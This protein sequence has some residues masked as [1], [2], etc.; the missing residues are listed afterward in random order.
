MSTHRKRDP[1]DFKARVAWESF[2]SSG[3]CLGPPCLNSAAIG[4]ATNPGLKMRSPLSRKT[5]G[6]SIFHTG[7]HCYL[8]GS[9]INIDVD[10]HVI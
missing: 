8:S 9:L 5:G 7:Q 1:A 4:L 3:R 2:G 6:T 10:H